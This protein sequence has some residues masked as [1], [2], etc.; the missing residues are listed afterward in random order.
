MFVYLCGPE[1]RDNGGREMDVGPGDEE[2]AESRGN[3][4]GIDQ[5]IRRLEGGTKQ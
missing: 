4:D 2:I 5:S 3:K 1:G